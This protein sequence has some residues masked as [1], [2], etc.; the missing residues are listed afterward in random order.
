[1]KIK[2]T[3]EDFIVEEI[4]DFP[5]AK[6]GAYAV[7]LLRKRGWSTAELIRGI[8]HKLK[9]PRACIAYGGRKDRHG[10]TSQYITIK[11]NESTKLKALQGSPGVILNEPVTPA[12]RI[13]GYAPSAQ[14]AG[15]GSPESKDSSPRPDLSYGR[16][17]NDGFR[18]DYSLEFVGRMDRPMGPDLIQG[19][20][21]KV[22]IRQLSQAKAQGLERELAQVR[23]Y[24]FPNYFDDQRFGGFDKIQG[25]L[26]QKIVKKQ[27]NGAVKIYLTAHFPT[28]KKDE[29][30]RKKYFFQHWKEWDLCLLKAKTPKEKSVFRAL[31]I[32]P[33][34][35]LGIIRD[36]PRDELS[37]YFNTYQ[38][39]LWNEVLRRVIAANAQS[40]RSCKGPVGDYVFYKTLNSVSSEYLRELSIPTVSSKAVLS[41]LIKD[42]YEELL[43][44]DGVR[45]P[46]FNLK[47]IR[48]AFFK[49]VGRKAI[50]IP[51]DL[52]HEISNDETRPGLKKMV[53]SFILGRGSYATMF[54]KRCWT[55]S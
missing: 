55:F 8:A 53:L 32:N 2:S 50:V 40:L 33:S 28:D 41:G 23:T 34:G 43:R 9:I 44:E 17:Q 48:Q 46:M 51:Q 29:K 35:F 6:K 26:A 38:S 24:G 21:F 31:K 10:L 4:A 30:E 15:E 19:N 42:F 49:S 47:D 20:R 12:Y 39:C 37:F 7:Y 18:N 3:P 11:S 1:V 25:F 27:Y 16:A 45:L 36:I 54:I 14:R 22:V 52:S 5:F 13:A